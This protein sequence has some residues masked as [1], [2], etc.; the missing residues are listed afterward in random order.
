M[1]TRNARE[2]LWPADGQKANW[3]MCGAPRARRVRFFLRYPFRPAPRPYPRAF[4][5]AADDTAVAAAM[6][7]GPRYVCRRRRT[8]C[9]R[10]SVLV[11]ACVRVL[12][13]ARYRV[14]VTSRRHRRRPR[15]EPRPYCGAARRRARQ[16][17]MTSAAAMVGRTVVRARAHDR[18]GRPPVR[19][20]DSI[21]PSVAR[22]RANDILSFYL[23]CTFFFFSLFFYYTC[24][25]QF[26]YVRK[27]R[28]QTA[29]PIEHI[30]HFIRHLNFS[31]QYSELHCCVTWNVNYIIIH[32]PSYLCGLIDFGYR[33]HI[34][35]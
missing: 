34:L 3:R 4:D 32:R 6:V 35:I 2:H 33:K 9:S 23:F 5:A 31:R 11:C 10:V 8:V 13:W 30:F 19:R 17:N 1:W 7:G 26:N 25:L 12:V 16:P 29:K 22:R 18:R 24:V 15:H 14:P 21:R 27:R 28:A 20:T